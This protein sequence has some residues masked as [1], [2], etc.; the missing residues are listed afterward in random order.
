M[1]KLIRDRSS[2]HVSTEQTRIDYGQQIGNRTDGS[3]GFSFVRCAALSMIAGFLRSTILEPMA[4]RTLSFKVAL[5]FPERSRKFPCIGL[6]AAVALPIH[7]SGFDPWPWLW[8]KT[9]HRPY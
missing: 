7:P 6:T 3:H 4:G 9:M 5:I 8:L 1:C 2:V